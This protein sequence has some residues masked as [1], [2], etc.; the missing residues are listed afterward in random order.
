[1]ESLKSVVCLV[2]TGRLFDNNGVIWLK[3]GVVKRRVKFKEKLRRLF[4][5]TD[6]FHVD[7]LPTKAGID[8]LDCT[9]NSQ[10][11]IPTRMKTIS[12]KFSTLAMILQNRCR[13]SSSGRRVKSAGDDTLV[14]ADGFGCCEQRGL[15]LEKAAAPNGGDCHGI[16]VAK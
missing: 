7:E 9:V 5:I 16:G 10:T 4:Q 6:R 1:M 15:H 14:I 8:K 2:R 12:G 3:T 13:R 11:A